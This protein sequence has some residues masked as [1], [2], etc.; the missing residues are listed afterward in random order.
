MTPARAMIPRVTS[1][2]IRS[3]ARSEPEPPPVS[4]VAELPNQL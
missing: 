1:R 2:M 4:T 3:A